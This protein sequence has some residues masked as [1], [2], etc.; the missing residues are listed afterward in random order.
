MKTT[1]T[2]SATRSYLEKT[3]N[4]LFKFESQHGND[5]YLM[6]VIVN[7]DTFNILK[8][9]MDDLNLISNRESKISDYERTSSKGKS[10][11]PTELKNRRLFYKGCYGDIY[12]ISSI[13]HFKAIREKING[14]VNQDKIAA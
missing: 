13:K 8:F 5:S 1:N 11:V 7:E 10:Y 6:K 2:K 12:K 14:C 3:S 9:D 4:H